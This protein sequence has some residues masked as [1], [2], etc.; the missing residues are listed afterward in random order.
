MLIMLSFLSLKRDLL[1]TVTKD[2]DGQACPPL[3]IAAR[4]GHDKAV[5]SL[6]VKFGHGARSG[7]GSSDDDGILDLDITGN[8]IFDDVEI[9]GATAL[10]CAAGAGHFKVV[11]TLVKAGA[12]VD[13]TTE[14]HS[15]PLRAACYEGHTDIVRFLIEK[16]QADVNMVNKYDNTC[17][18]IAAYKGHVEIVRYHTL[19]IS[20]YT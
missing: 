2:G 20:E 18:M 5:H 1:E 7:C 16:A 17:L 13:K 11:K 8:V 3:V 14:S 6:I 19:F 4:N 10:W 12:Q 9:E 15:T